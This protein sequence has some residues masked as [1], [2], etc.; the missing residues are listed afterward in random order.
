MTEAQAAL[1]NQRKSIVNEMIMTER[2]YCQDLEIFQSYATAVLEADFLAEDTPVYRLL[3]CVEDMLSFQRNLLVL[4]ESNWGMPWEE[5]RW[6]V[7]LLDTEDQFKACYGRY[8]WE[9][10][11]ASKTVIDD[12]QTLIAL[13]YI[14]NAKSELSAFI[15]KP[16]SRGCK[17]PLLFDCLVKVSFG[18]PYLEEFKAAAQ[19]ARRIADAI[20]ESSRLAENEWTAE[21]LRSRVLDWKGHHTEDFGKLLLDDVF[22]V[23]KSEIDREYH[24]FLF[25]NILLYC[26]EVETDGAGNILQAAP[27]PRPKSKSILAKAPVARRNPRLLLKGRILTKNVAGTDTNSPAPELILT[28]RPLAQPLQFQRATSIRSVFGGK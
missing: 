2:K 12:E 28:S 25:E 8:A 23:T 9:Y 13:N 26:K 3:S 20:C 5:Q 27:K 22:I 17:Y 18:H 10:P 7:P 19:A 21:M 24:T 11:A 15:A 16:V 6:G 14:L 4:F 1:D